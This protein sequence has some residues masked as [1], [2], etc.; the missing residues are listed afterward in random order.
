[1]GVG[2]WVGAGLAA[3]VLAVG[4]LYNRLIRLRN[5]IE[6]TWAD[7][8]V[9]LQRRYDLIP[10]LVRTVEAYAAH[11]KGVLA[12]V[13]EARRRGLAAG[14]PGDQAAAEELME[15][16][17]G[18]V[19]MVAEAYP[20]LKA[21][22]SFS[23]LQAELANTENQIAFSRQLYN[24]TVTAFNTFIQSFPGRLLAGPLGYEPRL[25]F[26]AR[27]AARRRPDVDL[28]GSGA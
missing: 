22:A 19:N 7:L 13:T 8:D 16:A 28:G 15:H 4:L 14:D 1:M 26:D 3:L 25:L 24:D 10:N 17:L 21:D 5:R 27:E 18:R 23:D 2:V 11:E 12:E 6:M 9:V 20:D